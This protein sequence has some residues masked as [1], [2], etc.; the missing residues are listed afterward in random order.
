MS[1]LN[2][3]RKKRLEESGAMS[4]RECVDEL[5]RVESLVVKNKEGGDNNLYVMPSRLDGLQQDIYASL[6]IERRDRPFCL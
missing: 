4:F 5:S 2:D 3:G 1:R 6:G